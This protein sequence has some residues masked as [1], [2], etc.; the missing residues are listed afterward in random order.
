MS[1]VNLSGTTSVELVEHQTSCSQDGQQSIAV[2]I[3]A[4]AAP[5]EKRY[6]TDFLFLNQYFNCA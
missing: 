6:I 2:D 3:A 5:A 1:G 4:E